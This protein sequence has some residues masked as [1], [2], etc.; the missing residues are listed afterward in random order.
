MTLPSGYSISPMT[1]DEVTMLG[2]WA[3]EEGWNPGLADL[4]LARRVDP[5]AFIAL[6]LGSALAGGGSIFSYDGR[7]GFM[8]LFIMRGDLRNRGLG[9]ELWHW[10]RDHLVERLEPGAVIGMDGVYEMVPF[11]ERGGFSPA[12]RDVRF[13]G[14]AVGQTHPD[15]SA[16][17]EPDFNDVDQF[18][19]AYFPV[20]RSAFLK[21]WLTAP[22]VQAMGVRENGKIVAYGVARPCRVGFKIGPLFAERDDLAAHVLETLM[23]KIAGSQVQ[24]DLPEVNDAAVAL[25]KGFGMAEVFGCVRLYLGP[26]PDLPMKRIFAVTSLEFG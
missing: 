3:A 24:I 11:Y 23:A 26:S 8:G 17:G 9:T 14:T 25:V 2:D 21:R 18:D 13:Q 19:R 20:P 22:G 7:F 12:Y 6:R 10:R 5:D 4:D 15:V 1:D 16:L